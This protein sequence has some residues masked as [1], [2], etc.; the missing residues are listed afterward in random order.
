MLLLSFYHSTEFYVLAALLAACVVAW[1]GVPK[2]RGEA[3]GH[4]LAGILGNEADPKADGADDS[5]DGSLIVEC[6]PDGTVRLVRTGLDGMTSSGAVSMAATLTGFELV[7]NERRS[8]GYSND[9]A[10]T[11]VEW[12]LD[13]LGRERYTVRYLCEDSGA[14]CNFT[15]PVRDGLRLVRPI[16]R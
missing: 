6:R 7:I 12:V 5:H 10:C 13:F 16:R 2:G 4:L 3:V 1:F 14:Q 9:P 11:S 8:P 15:F